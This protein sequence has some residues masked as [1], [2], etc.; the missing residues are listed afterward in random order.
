M[1][2]HVMSLPLGGRLL[3]CGPTR[4]VN[5]PYVVLGR[6]LYHH[7]RVAGRTHADRG[8]LALGDPVEG[9]N[10]I[11]RLTREERS[12]LERLFRRMR[13]DTGEDLTEELAARLAPIFAKED[14]G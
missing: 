4:D 5:F 2:T 14:A 12:D 9:R 6:A 11:D 13:E 1:R 10:W 7:A 3:R 8:T